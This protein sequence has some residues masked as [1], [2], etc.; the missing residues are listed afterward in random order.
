MI[1]IKFRASDIDDVKWSRTE[2]MIMVVKPLRFLMHKDIIYKFLSFLSNATGNKVS[3]KDIKKL[4]PAAREKIFLSTIVELEYLDI[5]IEG[6]PATGGIVMVK[7]IEIKNVDRVEYEKLLL[8]FTD[9]TKSFPV[10]R[11]ERRDKLIAIWKVPFYLFD[12]LD[13]MYVAVEKRGKEKIFYAIGEKDEKV[14]VSGSTTK[15]DDVISKYVRLWAIE[16]EKIFAIYEKTKNYTVPPNIARD[17][18]V[19]PIR[20]KEIVDRSVPKDVAEY[21]FRGD[22]KEV[23]N[24]SILT[25][26]MYAVAR[27]NITPFL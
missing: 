10:L 1:R 6:I 23:R 25:K 11:V 19:P 4:S 26:R 12:E 7:K 3:W 5:E 14:F 24:I 16:L 22:Y 8:K 2:R 20:F 21:L 18:N 27:R 17:H 15:I 9:K 13:E